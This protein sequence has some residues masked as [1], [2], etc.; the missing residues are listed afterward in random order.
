[1]IL[2]LGAAWLG[3]GQTTVLRLDEVPANH[4]GTLAA[5]APWWTTLWFVVSAVLSPWA[6]RVA[7]IVCAVGVFLPLRLSADQAR[8][9]EAVR[10]PLLVWSGLV[11][12]GSTLPN[13]VKLAVDRPRPELAS[14]AAFGSSFPSS[15]A[16]AVTVAL[17]GGWL[18]FAPEWRLHGWPAW[19][20]VAVVA[21]VCFARVALAVHYVTD[22]VG[23]VGLSL[24]FLAASLL[25]VSAVEARSAR[26]A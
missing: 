3:P 24:T 6:W 12:V 19:L 7:A 21:L 16:A 20:A 1:M 18:V 26:A 23:G 14:V 8:R 5:S 4:F 15:H 25:I 10:V 17:I 2:L 11:L 13:L 22:V 9:R